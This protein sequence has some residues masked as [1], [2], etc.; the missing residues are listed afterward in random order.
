L[1]SNSTIASG[2]STFVRVILV[3]IGAVLAL[4]IHFCKMLIRLL[5][6]GC[7][8]WLITII[9][10]STVFF[11]VLLSIFI[12]QFAIFIAVVFVC[13]AVYNGKKRYDKRKE[14]QEEQQLQQLQQ[15]TSVEDGVPEGVVAN[16]SRTSDEIEI[17]KVG[18]T[19]V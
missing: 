12:R 17:E 5:G 9:E 2:I 19:T 3:F 18:P 14:E 11:S 15:V 6:E 10:V 8:T 16:F 4:S 13:A 1:E 7:L